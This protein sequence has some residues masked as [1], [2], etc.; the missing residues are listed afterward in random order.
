MEGIR[1][2]GKKSYVNILLPHQYAKGDSRSVGFHGLM[3]IR[4]KHVYDTPARYIQLSISYFTIQKQKEPLKLHP[5]YLSWFICGF[6]Y[7]E[8]I[9][10]HR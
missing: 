3:Y 9:F 4:F 1:S 6:E 10:V 7:A 8:T 5:F 2:L